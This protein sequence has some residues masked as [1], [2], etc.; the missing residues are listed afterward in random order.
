MN[1]FG[2]KHVL[3]FVSIFCGHWAAAVIYDCNVE[4]GVEV[5]CFPLFFCSMVLFES[6]LFLPDPPSKFCSAH[7]TSS[8]LVSHRYLQIHQTFAEEKCGK[9]THDVRLQQVEDVLMPIPFLYKE[10][11]NGTNSKKGPG[12]AV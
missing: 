5:L 8:V 7:P 2:Q 3:S 12:K 9:N 4:Q 1:H 10:T 6:N 11:N